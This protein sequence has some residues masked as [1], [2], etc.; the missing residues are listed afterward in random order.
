MKM[1]RLRH[2]PVRLD[3]PGDNW[4]VYPILPREGGWR[5]SRFLAK[6]FLRRGRRRESPVR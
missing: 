2:R 1:P 5:M 4:P 6:L 3:V